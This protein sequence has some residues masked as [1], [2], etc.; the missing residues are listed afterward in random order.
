MH[1]SNLSITSNA[2]TALGNVPFGRH[3]LMPLLA[4]YKRPN[5]KIA[6]W[7][8]SGDL[9]PLRKGLYVLGVSV[10]KDMQ[11]AKTYL[12][13]HNYRCPSTWLDPRGKAELQKPPTVPLVMVYNKSGQLVQLEKGQ[14][15]A[16]DVQA[17]S[18]WING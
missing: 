12:Q 16:E 6:R 8:A 5:D 18:R 3:L 1:K 4:E 7:L 15:F 11:A 14:L 17:L 9:V 2:F 10:D 13:R